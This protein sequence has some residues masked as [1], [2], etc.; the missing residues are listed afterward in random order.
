VSGAVVLVGAGAHGRGT[1]EIL[2]ARRA[3]GLETP[4]VAG[5]V[6]DHAAAGE[7]GGLPLLGDVAWLAERARAEGLAAI[8]AIADPAA[9]R[10]LAARLEDAVPRWESAVHPTVV[11]ASGVDVADGAILGAGVIVAYDTVIEAHTTVNLGATIGH[12]CRVGRFATVAPGV[13]VTGNVTIGE[14]AL[15]QTNAT[16]VPGVTIGDGARV[17]PGAV[18]LRDAEAGALYMGNPAR[19]MPDPVGEGARGAR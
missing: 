10:A 3:A 5:F 2:R 8:L 17:G 9:K 6:D 14:G 13:N 19:R 18:L 1:L 11:L 12:D 16:V 4:E 7:I 15:I